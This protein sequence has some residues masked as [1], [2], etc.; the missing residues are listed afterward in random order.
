MTTFL[1]G[2]SA[3]KPFCQNW[4]LRKSRKNCDVKFGMFCHIES[5]KHKD[6]IADQCDQMLELKVA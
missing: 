5:A 1:L 4:C 3:I 2:I 6:T